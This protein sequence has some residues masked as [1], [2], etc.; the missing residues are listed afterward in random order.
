MGADTAEQMVPP[1]KI[2][3]AKVK[4]FVES[5]LQHFNASQA[6]RESML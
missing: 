5:Y 6:A 4:L 3:E 2:P 1:R